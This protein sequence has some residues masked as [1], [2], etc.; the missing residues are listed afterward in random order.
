ML[1]EVEV[2]LMIV[3]TP[4]R[5]QAL[6]LSFAAMTI[7]LTGCSGTSAPPPGR[8]EIPGGRIGYISYTPEGANYR[9]AEYT[10]RPDGSEKTLISESLVPQQEATRATKIKINSPGYADWP[11]SN[12]G[13]ASP[14][15]TRE[16]VILG[17]NYTF[18]G[19]EI[20]PGIY[21]VNPDATIDSDQPQPIFPIE[22]PLVVG[23]PIYAVGGWNADN[24]ILFSRLPS[25]FA[26]G[27][28]VEWFSMDPDG[29]NMRS[30]ARWSLPQPPPGSAGLRA[31]GGEYGVLPVSDA[32]TL[33]YIDGS[34]Q[35][36]STPT[37]GG[38]P[39]PLTTEGFNFDLS[40]R[41]DGKALAF[42]GGSKVGEFKGSVYVMN[43]DG[44]GRT[45]VTQDPPGGFS[46]V[47]S[48]DAEL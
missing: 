36:F 18:D 35:I 11:L 8:A 40:L 43:L 23:N 25:T 3:H 37:T 29:S 9:V 39:R 28:T 26:P 14:D 33:V 1:G 38:T 24:K 44:S 22:S 42:T 17:P 12:I 41:T 30:I 2:F 13:Y 32:R 48:Y 46:R 10:S 20:P 4:S 45:R 6:M 21:L 5:R 34:H 47:V 7:V 19:R 31:S 27:G 15:G 16:A